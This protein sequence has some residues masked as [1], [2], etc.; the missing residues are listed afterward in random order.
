MAI[1]AI[2]SPPFLP[3]V[4]TRLAANRNKD[5]AAKPTQLQAS[6]LWRLTGVKS[7][8]RAPAETT[9]APKTPPKIPDHHPG[10]VFKK[11]EDGTCIWES[12]AYDGKTRLEYGPLLKGF[13][14][15]REW[16]KKVDESLDWDPSQKA[17]GK[18]ASL[19]G[20]C[21]IHHGRLRLT[22]R[23]LNHLEK[24]KIYLFTPTHGSLIDTPILQVALEDW[25]PGHVADKRF[26]KSFLGRA[27]TK[28]GKHVFINRKSQKS[29][30]RGLFRAIKMLKNPSHRFSLVADPQGTRACGKKGPDGQRMDGDLFEQEMGL[31]RGAAEIFYRTGR[32]GVELVP[33]VMNGTGRVLPKGLL[34]RAQTGE[35]IE[36]IVG[37]PI[38]L[39]D[40]GDS[41]KSKEEEDQ[42][43]QKI[44]GEIELFYRAHYK[45]PLSAPK[46]LNKAP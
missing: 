12:K 13:K 14:E 2:S 27:M 21:I 31:L 25:N 19:W 9:K 32:Y 24:G 6:I 8:R 30:I 37:K 15:S 44:M 42:L 4:P 22:V 45:A 1:R 5:A 40:M 11:L 33:I 23:G 36:I 29:R 43:I 18:F 3:T 34:K 35:E 39:S 17:Y 7:G 20:Q 16:I 38:K 26:E 46:L 10:V 28:S 41:P